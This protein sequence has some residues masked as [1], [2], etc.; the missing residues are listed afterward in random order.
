MRYDSE[1]EKIND[2]QILKNAGRR[3]GDISDLPE[4]LRRQ[5]NASKMDDLEEKIIKTIRERYDGFASIDE[6]IVGLYR[7]FGYISEDRKF[8][9]NKIYR[10]TKAQHLES[11]QKRKGIVKVRL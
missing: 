9:A 3:L 6:V 1:M 8:I 11:V 2:E 10:M 4:A 7:D 5:L